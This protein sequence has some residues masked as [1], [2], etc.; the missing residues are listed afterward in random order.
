M[1]QRPVIEKLFLQWAG[2]PLSIMTQISAN[3]SNRSYYRCTGSTQTCVA[4]KNDD[5][6]ENEAFFYFAKI[7]KEQGVRVPEVFAIS[8][9]RTIYLQEDLGDT[10]LYSYLQSLHTAD[11]NIG[12]ETI[13]LY[14][15]ALDD[16]LTMQQLGK[17][18]AIDFTR[19][20][21]RPRMDCQALQWD[22]NYF[23]Y[24]FLKLLHV[25]FDEQLL[26][27][28]FH[29]FIDYL[30]NGDCDYLLYRDFQTRNIMTTPDG[31]L[32][33][34]DF[35]G[36]RQGS[37]LYDVASLLYS[38]KGKLT[39]QQRDE[40]LNYYLDGFIEKQSKV[41]KEG[42]SSSSDGSVI[43]HSEDKM[44]LCSRFYAYVLA[45]MMQTMGAYGYRGLFERKDY[46]LNS[47]PLAV[48][49][50]K[51]VLEQHP[52]SLHLPE[53]EKVWHWLID[54]VGL[55]REVAN[56]NNVVS[57][58]DNASQ[59]CLAPSSLFVHVFSF[60][61]KHGYPKDNSGNGGG[62]AFDCRALPNPGRYEQYKKMTGKD[63][64]VVQFLENEDNKA[65]IDFFF[66][67]AAAVVCQHVD[68][69]IQRGFDNL[70][71]GFGCT[72]GQHR[73]VYFA[74][75]VGRYLHQHYPNIMID[76]SHCQQPQLNDTIYSKCNSEEI[77][78]EKSGTKQA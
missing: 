41:G 10:T 18:G 40:L 27:D 74:E 8:D 51:V 55:L 14:H 54:N 64:P 6:R 25:P 36:A 9:D 44:S 33:Y 15:H 76:V 21:P 78:L 5:V 7:L 11:N 61:F 72:G 26:E 71:V 24:D 13:R 67:H 38:S 68:N 42:V 17:D 30:L 19:A 22:L 49:N 12:P 48:E 23:K 62:Y 53:L 57:A 66:D 16:L 47:I 39:T 1:E 69:F 56:K 75:R 3:G 28:D 4:A 34:I 32:Y 63:L 73:S 20:Y 77:S 2:E 59:L 46:F 35:Q 52:L 43:H 50:L 65:K 29:Q 37:H 58:G 70:M 45:R 60:S 31:R